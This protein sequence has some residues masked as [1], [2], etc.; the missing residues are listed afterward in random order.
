MSASE[1]GQGVVWK[2]FTIVG[3]GTMYFSK[4]N[5][6][7][8][9]WIFSEDILHPLATTPEAL[10][11][12]VHTSPHKAATK[13]RVYCSGATVLLDLRGAFSSILG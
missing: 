12:A 6:Y 11:L 2:V 8:I 3:G 13:A 7:S 10:G 1:G 4:P 5:H 9:L